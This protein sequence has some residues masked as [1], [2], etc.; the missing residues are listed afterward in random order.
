MLKEGMVFAIE[1][2]VNAGTP[3][4]RLLDDDWSVVTADGRLS[5]HFEHSIAIT[6]NG[7]EVL[8]LPVTGA[9]G[10][11][12][13]WPGTGTAMLA[14][15]A[16]GPGFG[17]NLQAIRLLPGVGPPMLRTGPPVRSDAADRDSITLAGSGV[18]GETR[19]KNEEESPAQA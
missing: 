17:P 15:S 19:T 11:L 16:R 10:E 14:T 18:P 8:T 12:H 1:P 9:W 4:T 3:E 2:M 7:P 13:G 6:E 5:A